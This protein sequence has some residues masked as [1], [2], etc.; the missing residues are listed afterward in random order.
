LSELESPFLQDEVLTP[1]PR[2]ELDPMLATL[3]HQSP[4]AANREFYF[5][6]G[7]R[8]TPVGGGAAPLTA[9]L[10]K[11]DF[12]PDTVYIVKGTSDSFLNSARDFHKLWG[13]KP[14]DFESLEGLI[15]LIAKAKI[16]DKRI[17][18]ISHA[19]DGFKIPLFKG[20]PAAF[21]IAQK[22]IEA[23]N[24]GDG[25][26]MDELL[27]KLVDLD[28]TTDQG[29]VAWN[30]LLVHLESN[31]PD[32]LKPF[33]LTSKTKPAGDLDLL[34]RRCAD[35]VAVASADSVFTK[36][37]RK[38]LMGAQS[39]LKRSAAE[40][41]TLAASVTSSGFTFTMT[42]PDRDMVNRLRAAVGALDDRAFR[43]TL[44]DARAK[45]KDKWLD[46]RGCRIGHQ[47][48]YLEA[49]AI[50]MGTDGCT[51][52]DWWS[53]YPGEAPI[54]DQQVSSAAS[55]KGI[56][57]S[58]AAAEAAMNRWGAREITGWSGVAAAEKPERYFNDFLVKQNGVFP[59]YEVDY[60]GTAP[61]EKHTLYWN[62]GK[63]KERW[64]ESMWDRAPKKQ[65][66]LISRGWGA[67]TPRMPTLALHL[68]SKSGSQVDPQKI[69][70]VPEPE[71]RDHIIEVKKP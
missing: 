68:K 34:L 10:G 70:L 44:K 33:G 49:F 64:L 22:Q 1:E 4:F 61:K 69:Y 56:V 45:L 66:Q 14:V 17:R 29:A 40:V 53:G 50:L 19:W 3:V 16:P 2:R 62:S 24:A 48:K 12:W 7:G 55:F 54:R 42:P 37:V 28:K 39:R 6:P 8:A 27:G 11:P 41:N 35:L 9:P 38:S 25:L 31:S 46:F 67:K 20:S 43:K 71:F 63:G 36:A 59:V 23:L 30:A 58:S 57:N 51:A 26:L 5:A 21:T 65:V 32:A 52:P 13:F 60:S 47:P 15:G 18:V